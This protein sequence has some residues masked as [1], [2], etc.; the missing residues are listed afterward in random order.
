MSLLENLVY[1][2]FC[3]EIKKKAAELEKEN[4]ALKRQLELKQQ[5]INDTN[6]YWKKKMHEVKRKVKHV[7]I[8]I[9]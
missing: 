3:Q 7:P 8:Q 6:K 2:P 9:S 5:H 4:T 1:N